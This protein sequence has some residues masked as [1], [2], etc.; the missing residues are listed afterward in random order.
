MSLSRGPSRTRAS[1]WRLAVLG[2]VFLNASVA[3]AQAP[4]YLSPSSCTNC[5][6]HKAQVTWSEQYDGGAGDKQHLKA[7]T[8]LR[9]PKFKEAFTKY[10]LA[11][12]VEAPAKDPYCTSCHATIVGGEPKIGV[13]CQSCHGPASLYLKPHQEKDGYK[14]N[15]QTFV[16]QGMREV[17]RNPKQWIKDCLNCHVLGNTPE[18]DQ[19]IATAGHPDGRDFNVGA[20]IKTV[21]GPGHWGSVVTQDRKVDYTESSIEA[22]AVPEKQRLLARLKT[23]SAKAVAV[24]ADAAAPTAKTPATPSPAP[25]PGP[26]PV[27]A[28]PVSVA[29]TA[30]AG[31]GDTAGAGGGTVPAAGR[32]TAPG[33][34]PATVANP[35]GPATPA[36]VTPPTPRGPAAPSNSAVLATPP[37]SPPVRVAKP[38]AP[39]PLPPTAAAAAAPSEPAPL[40]A[41]GVVASIQ[42]RLISLL[43]TLLSRDVVLP[44][45]VTPPAAPTVYRGADADLIRLQD[46]VIAL[47][48]EALGTAPRARPK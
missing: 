12:K 17:V 33:A 45:P 36:V 1:A 16:K 19:A 26:S 39:D 28:P 21:M 29:P 2:A 4:E 10:A 22:L 30:S 15:Y 9:A 48:L 11:A 31:R 7:L 3:A 38:P 37:P 20:K 32:G 23:G 5:H 43:G 34:P 8:Q 47:A 24:A 18:K 42:G 27:P 46:E 6:D 14:T 40:T 41:A 13:T 25:S 44:N 35:T